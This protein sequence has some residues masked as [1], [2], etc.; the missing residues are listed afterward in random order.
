[1]D[2]L[3]DSDFYIQ[4]EEETQNSEVDSNEKLTVSV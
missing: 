2:K 4:P 3:K 1:M